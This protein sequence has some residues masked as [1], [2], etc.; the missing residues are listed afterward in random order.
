MKNHEIEYYCELFKP[1]NFQPVLFAHMTSE[2]YLQFA[3]LAFFCWHRHSQKYSVSNFTST[4]R[5]ERFARLGQVAMQYFWRL[6]SNVPYG[7]QLSYAESPCPFHVSAHNIYI[8]IYTNI[9]I[10]I[11]VFKSLVMPRSHIYIYICIYI[12]LWRKML[13]FTGNQQ[14]IK[15]TKT[16]KQQ[17]KNK[18]TQNPTPPKKKQKTKQKQK[19]Q[20]TNKKQ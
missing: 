8:Y 20:K 6:Q 16:H 3:Y 4:E 7:P 18:Q 2:C 1:V 17:T 13:H 5:A 12:H 11:Y 19:K 15:K 14:I 10:Y 9:I